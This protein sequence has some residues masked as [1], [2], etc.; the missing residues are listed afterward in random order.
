[1]LFNDF[2][3]VF[4]VLS[5]LFQNIAEPILSTYLTMK[6]VLRIILLLALIFIGS[7]VLFSDFSLE[8]PENKTLAV[9]KK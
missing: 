5:V 1:M 7:K 3:S 2:K 9:V 6:N 8:K 4:F